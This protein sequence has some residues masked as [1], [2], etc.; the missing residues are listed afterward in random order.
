MFGSVVI[1]RSDLS[2]VLFRWTLDLHIVNHIP[3]PQ[4]K[5]TRNFSA[6]AKTGPAIRSVH[7]F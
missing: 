1:S 2:K 4:K 7:F 5:K 3:P 6:V